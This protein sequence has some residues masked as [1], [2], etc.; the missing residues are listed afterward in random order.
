MT[1]GLF[2]SWL[3]PVCNF[4]VLSLLFTDP[5]LTLILSWT[6]ECVSKMALEFFLGL[7]MMLNLLSTECLTTKYCCYNYEGCCSILFSIFI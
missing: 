5:T 1:L 3:S 4:A 7:L 6:V 2:G